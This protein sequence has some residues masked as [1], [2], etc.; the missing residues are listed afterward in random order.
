MLG[1]RLLTGLAGVLLVAG[2]GG[3]L[4]TLGTTLDRPTAVVLLVLVA[5]MTEL[6]LEGYRQ[7]GDGETPYW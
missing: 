7:A 4:V 5:G 2:V 6:C 3:A 1:M